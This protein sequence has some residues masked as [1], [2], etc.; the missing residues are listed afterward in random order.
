MAQVLNRITQWFSTRCDIKLDA[1]VNQV[2][3]CVENGSL[4]GIYADSASPTDVYIFKFLPNTF[5]GTEPLQNGFM[6]VFVS[7]TLDVSNGYKVYINQTKALNYEITVYERTKKLVDNNVIGHFVKYFASLTTPTSF[8]KLKNFIQDKAGLSSIDAEANL[9]RNTKFMIFR[10]GNNKRPPI[11][12]PVP[13]VTTPSSLDW[14]DASVNLVKYKFILTEAVV[15]YKIPNIPSLSMRIK[16]F[17]NMMP[18][19]SSIKFHDIIDMIYQLNC[20]NRLSNCKIVCNT[21]LEIYFQLAVTTYAMYLNNFVH[22][23]LHSGNVWVKRTKPVDIKYTLDGVA[24]TPSYTLKSCNNFSML[25][26]YDR[27]YKF[28]MKNPLLENDPRLPNYNQT[29]ELIEQRDFVKI[30]CYTMNNFLPRLI[31]LGPVPGIMS[32]YKLDSID[33]FKMQIYYDLLNCICKDKTATF[34]NRPIIGGVAWEPNLLKW[35]NDRDRYRD[36]WDR[37]FNNL[38]TSNFFGNVVT[39]DYYECYLNKS[40]GAYD[41]IT[42]RS[43]SMVLNHLNP[44]LYTETLNTM[45]EIIEKLAD[46]VNKY[47]PNKI[48]KNNRANAH[49]NYDVRKIIRP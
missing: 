17:I 19:N 13:V 8:D 36:F 40:G 35:P 22:N 12:D 4:R 48:K 6:K 20:A 31:R 21:I 5:Y 37:I 23:D 7:N 3:S 45:P 16:D 10:Q 14:P 43:S 42:R 46:V 24:G 34:V 18:I 44:A 33:I 28:H 30:L 47:N 26:D 11:N 41:S 29:N 39:N 15:P 9:L 25:Y 27:A 32:R 2:V 49:H 1:S 38:D